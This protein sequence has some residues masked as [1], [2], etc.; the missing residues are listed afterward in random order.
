VWSVRER[1]PSSCAALF[2]LRCPAEVVGAD[3]GSCLGGRS[4]QKASTHSQ[5]LL[6]ALATR[7]RRETSNALGL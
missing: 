7:E 4:R 1:A 2:R 5:S 3:M 6:G